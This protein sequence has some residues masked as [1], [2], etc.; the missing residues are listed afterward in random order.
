MESILTRCDQIFLIDTGISS[1]Y[2]GVLS[3]VEVMY[4]LERIAGSS[5]RWKEKEVISALYVETKSH[6]ELARQERILTL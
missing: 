1:A 4:T 2:G 5:G 3:A 6:V